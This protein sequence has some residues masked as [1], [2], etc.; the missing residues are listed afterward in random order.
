MFW[1]SSKNDKLSGEFK[2]FNAVIFKQ[3]WFENRGSCIIQNRNWHICCGVK[4]GQ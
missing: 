1:R 4:N 3:V 2:C